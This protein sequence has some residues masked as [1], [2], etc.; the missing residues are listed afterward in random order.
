MFL[1]LLILLPLIFGA[2]LAITP[3]KKSLGY[4][5]AAVSIYL[6]IFTLLAVLF[7]S[8]GS[9][10]TS[11]T[12]S[13]FKM[14]DVQTY[15]ALDLS[16]LGG[17][18]VLLTTFV[19][20]LLFLYFISVKQSYKNNFYGLLLIM[21]AGLNGVFMAQDLLLFYF[22]WEIVLI[23]IYFLIGIWGGKNK[24]KAN[25]TFFIYTIFGS[26]L[27]LAGI[28]YIGFGLQPESYLLK[29][30]KDLTVQYQSLQLLP[31]LFLIAFAIKI[32][33]F[34]L[35]TWQPP[36]YKASD[37]F[38]TIILSALMAK[39]GLF[40]V[41]NW[42]IGMFPIKSLNFDNLLYVAGFGLV[43]ASLIALRANH[44]KKIIAFSSIAHLALIFMSLFTFSEIGAKGAYFQMF[45]HGIV[46]LGM[47]LS[48]DYMHRR[49][50]VTDIKSVRGLA[51]I[52][53]AIAVFWTIF[54]LSNLS[55]PLTSNFIGEFSMLNALFQYNPVLCIMGCI[56]AILSAAYTWRM[57]NAILLGS[58][59]HIKDK[60]KKMQPILYFVF[61]I[62]SFA[63]ILLGTYPSIIFNLIQN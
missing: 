46:V 56:G 52:D 36:V 28:I 22:F 50:S 27:M 4:F 18:M 57:N 24:V 51:K 8:D 47:W 2:G 7:N 20:S 37:T 53:P 42:F 25:T 29:D 19:Y 1:V 58:L 12:Q 15:I 60:P 32:P 49:Y 9:I 14:G 35:H 34:P 55:L 38:V 43:Y 63:V 44:L 40:A 39:M 62:L 48:Y 41:V 16:G 17:L 6:F 23:P 10:Q 54:C 11:I 13:W 31:V 61:G 45:S 26:F 33:I 59:E 3:Y 5:G 21:F 30:L